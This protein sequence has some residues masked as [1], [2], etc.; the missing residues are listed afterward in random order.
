MDTAHLYTV[1]GGCFDEVRRVSGLTLEEFAVALKRDTSQ[2]HRMITGAVRP[3]IELV[4][5][6]DRFRAAL[7]IAL[8]RLTP[9][10]A[11]TTQLTVRRTA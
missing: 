4:F 1:L 6:V 11:I 9:E 5:A 2:V 3:Q 10:I 7:I 8:A